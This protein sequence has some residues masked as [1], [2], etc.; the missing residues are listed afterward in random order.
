[1]GRKAGVSKNKIGESLKPTSNFTE[2]GAG[3]FFASTHHSKEPFFNSGVIQA[4]FEKPEHDNSLEQEANQKA[5]E[6][7]QHSKQFG[8]PSEGTSKVKPIENIQKNIIQ[9]Q[10]RGDPQSGVSARRAAQ[11]RELARD[12]GNFITLWHSPR[13]TESHHS[14]I[15]EAMDG[16][17]GEAFTNEFVRL[18]EANQL[19][20]GGFIT[21]HRV[22]ATHGELTPERFAERGYVLARL[23]DRV[24]VQ[25]SEVWI[26][27]SGHTVT[28]SLEGNESEN[29]NTESTPIPAVP[30]EI[31]M[32]PN[33]E[34]RYGPRVAT[35]GRNVLRGAFPCL[36]ASLFENRTIECYSADGSITT[37]IH[38]QSHG[39]F[40]TYAGYDENGRFYMTWID[41]NNL[42]G[43]IRGTEANEP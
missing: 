43:R 21:S 30:E 12:P 19:S 3:A 39:D 20:S 23:A 9:L 18:A 32:A 2:R 1:M 34:T 6:V 10:H 29:E 37:L 11:L 22:T 7:A 4:K 16:Y 25:Q 8:S 36:S 26:H 24:L 15:I 14:I 13:T 27:P 41:E 33:P 38:Q 28:I 40:T 31:E 17:Y 35:A 5:N 42:E